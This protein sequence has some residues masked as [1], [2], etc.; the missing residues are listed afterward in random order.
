MYGVKPAPDEASDCGAGPAVFVTG[1]RPG[2]VGT[3]GGVV[4]PGGVVDGGV[5][6][7]LVGAVVGGV[8]GVVGG[9]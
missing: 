1:A 4:M 3:L 9:A 5:A 2:D 7:G 6:G 8:A